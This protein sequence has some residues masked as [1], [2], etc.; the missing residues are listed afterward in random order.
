MKDNEKYEQ[1]DGPLSEQEIEAIRKASPATDLSD[2]CF[3][4]RLFD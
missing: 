4:E 1:D 3:T 2:E